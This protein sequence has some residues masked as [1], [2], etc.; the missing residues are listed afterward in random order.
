MGKELIKRN[1]EF[2]GEPKGNFFSIQVKVDGKISRNHYTKTKEEMTAWIENQKTQYE[3]FTNMTET[4]VTIKE[5][6]KT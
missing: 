2:I 1:I 5:E 4:K 6:S 3:K